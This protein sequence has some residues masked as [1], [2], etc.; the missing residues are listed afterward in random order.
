MRI[1]LNKNHIDIKQNDNGLYQYRIGGRK[2]EGFKSKREAFK[3]AK[4]SLED[5]I[6]EK[7]KIWLKGQIKDWMMLGV[8]L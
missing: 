6:N 7:F 5:F 3:H 2:V 8:K 1:V 4:N